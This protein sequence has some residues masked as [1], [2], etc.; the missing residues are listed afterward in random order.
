[1]ETV[2]PVGS[3]RTAREKTLPVQICDCVAAVFE[4]Q[5]EALALVQLR[6]L[7]RLELGNDFDAS[8]VIGDVIAEAVQEIQVQVF[9]LKPRFLLRPR[10][11]YHCHNFVS[12]F[13]KNSKS[14]SKQIFSF[15]PHFVFRKRNFRLHFV[16]SFA[17]KEAGQVS[18]GWRR[19]SRTRS[20][21]DSGG[22]RS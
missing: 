4:R 22:R 20:F 14:D 7:G 12:F 3:S 13:F 9:V 8:D 10:Q 1:M 21:P 15:R 16:F 18:T 17:S 6:P 11:T 5:A 2:T 19:R